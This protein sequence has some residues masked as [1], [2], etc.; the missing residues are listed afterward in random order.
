MDEDFLDV[1]NKTSKGIVILL[2]FIIISLLVLGYIFAYKP[3]HFGLNTIKFEVGSELSKDVNTYLK[4]PVADTSQYKLDLSKVNKDEVGVYEYSITINKNK[5]IGKI[6][7]VDTT[8]PKFTVKDKIQVEVDDEEF[9]IGD[10]LDSCED[11]SLPCVVYF[12]NDSDSNF[13]KTIGSHTLTIVVADVY[14]NKKETTVTIEVLEKGKI[15]REEELDLVFSKSSIELPGF[16][17]EY[18][19]KL[20]KALKPDSDDAED[21]ASEISAEDIEKYIKTN[22]PSNSIKNTEI[23]SMLNKHGYIIG[24]VVKITLDNDK[25]V[26]MKKAAEQL[27]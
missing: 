24:F 7:I 14:K 13:F 8:P 19:I 1:N 25:I 5:Q 20:N 16:K 27:Y 2:F 15:V 9:F 12:K 22:Y 26:Y 17:D 4:K 18:Y 23:V 6:K 21:A 3:H 11:A 10:A